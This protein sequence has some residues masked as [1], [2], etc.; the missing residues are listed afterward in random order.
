MNDMEQKLKSILQMSETADVD[1]PYRILP[2][3]HPAWLEAKIDK[4]LS[5]E[6]KTHRI[7]VI[8]KGEPPILTDEQ[9]FDWCGSHTVKG[10]G[11]TRVTDEVIKVSKCEDCRAQAQRDLCIEYYKEV[12]DGNTK[13]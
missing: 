3:G 1:P 6:T 7:A 4:I 11:T 10:C 9:F 12:K 8:K 5:L 13:K 2:E